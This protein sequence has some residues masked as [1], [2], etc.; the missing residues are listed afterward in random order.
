MD[1]A[2]Q[3]NMSAS[4]RWASYSGA[5]DVW[6]WK[7]GID[8]ALTDE[9]RLRTT[10]S[11]DVRAAT[12]GEKF[13]RTGGL[14]N[15]TDYL[16]DPAGGL[17][18]GFTIF[19]NGSPDIQP[20][21]AKTMTVGFVYQ[22]VALNGFSIS[23]DWYSVEVTDNIN[24]AAAGDVLSGCYLDGDDELCA[25]ITR[26][27]L[28]STQDPS[29]NYISLVG[30]PFYN[31]NSVKASGVDF[32]INYG[33]PVEW[34]GGGE[35]VNVRAL[36]SYLRE[37]SNTTQAG[38]KTEIQ[39]RFGSPE[40]TFLV[41][42]G[43]SRGPLNVNLTARYTDEMIINPNW[44][45]LGTSNRWDV[46][47][48][49]INNEILVDARVGYRMELAEGNLNL[50]LNVNNLFDKAPQQYLTGAYSNFFSVGPGLGVTGDLRGRRY[51]IGANFEF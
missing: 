8:W 43:Y 30:V 28:P 1:M 50:Y 16:L 39:G 13:D 36:G 35:F 5:G 45:F 19:S 26:G 33:T 24:R 4:A 51:S 23:L 49:K 48:N 44:N 31:Q 29:I 10:I 20:E 47:D 7:G 21:E 6:S 3:V 22:P 15:G 46:A 40:F 38:A 9:L 42:G 18:Y 2:E 11:Q 34:F 17:S 27:G 14:G 32:E 12:M 41:N 25:L 37:R